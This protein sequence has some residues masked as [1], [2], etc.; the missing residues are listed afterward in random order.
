MKFLHSTVKLVRSFDMFGFK[1]DWNYTNQ[2][3]EFKTFI[4]GIASLMIEL[5]VL[6]VFSMRT[7]GMITKS[8][9]TI[10]LENTLQNIDTLNAV[11]NFNDTNF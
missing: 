3:S 9:P 5:F 7:Y 8:S 10:S 11:N 2:G 1:L 6:F 4:G